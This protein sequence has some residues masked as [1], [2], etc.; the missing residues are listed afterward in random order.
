MATETHGVDRFDQWRSQE[1]ELGGGPLPLPLLTGVRGY[2]TGIFLKLKVL[3]V[4]FRAFWASKLT[5]LWT[6]FFLRKTVEFQLNRL[7]KYM[8][9]S[10]RN[11]PFF[12]FCPAIRGGGLGPLVYVSG[13]DISQTNQFM[14]SE[15]ADK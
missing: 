9:A 2:N 8:L 1:C 6:R 5:P 7:H 15:P 10:D 11:T 13:L 14:D 3:V 4:C 12:L